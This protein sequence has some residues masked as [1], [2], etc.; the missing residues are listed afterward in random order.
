M[1]NDP[2]FKLLVFIV[3][4]GLFAAFVPTGNAR[5]AVAA[6]ADGTAAATA[7]TPVGRS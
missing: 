5:P 3:L 4:L 2:Y 7:E 1:K 6:S